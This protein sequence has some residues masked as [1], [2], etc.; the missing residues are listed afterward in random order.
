MKWGHT[1]AVSLILL[2]VALLYMGWANVDDLFGPSRLCNGFFANPTVH[3]DDKY[4]LAYTDS[5]CEP[6]P[7][8]HELFTLVTIAGMGL[9]GG[10]FYAKRRHQ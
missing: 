1:L 10:G 8:A 6:Y 2:G 5:G 3:L 4:A 7:F 9:L